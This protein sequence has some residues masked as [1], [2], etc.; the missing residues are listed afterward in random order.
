MQTTSHL[1]V[2]AK[3][4]GGMAHARVTLACFVSSGTELITSC[5]RKS[6]SE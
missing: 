2:A 4:E 5:I 6:A 3:P 1:A